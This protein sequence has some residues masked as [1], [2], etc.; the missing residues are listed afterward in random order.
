VLLRQRERARVCGGA[1]ELEQV[2]VPG[3]IGGFQRQHECTIYR[4]VAN[5]PLRH[6]HDSLREF[7][8]RRLVW[9]CVW[10]M[11]EPERR[12][13]FPAHDLR[14]LGHCSVLV[15]GA[16]TDVCCLPEKIIKK[17]KEDA[18]GQR[19]QNKTCFLDCLAT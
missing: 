7:D 10:M 18:L 5:L 14:G 19:T 11:G 15:E 13:W 8:R 9:S 12:R 17:R 16:A 1:G 6:D 3:F 4:A 2:R